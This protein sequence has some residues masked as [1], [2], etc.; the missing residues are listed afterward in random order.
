MNIKNN[1]FWFWGFI[2][3]AVLVISAVS[4]VGYKAYRF[5]NTPF[6][7]KHTERPN[8]RWGNMNFDED[9]QKFIRESRIKHRNAMFDL[10]KQQK[11]IHNKL[12][13][14]IS[15]ENPDAAIIQIYKDSTLVLS[16]SIMNETIFFY[17]T[18]KTQLSHEQMKTINNHINK[19]F[20]KSPRRR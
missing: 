9:Q 4:T 2:I 17:E 18:L 12:F 15:K 8:S 16:T 5:H 6:H 3:L 20:H 19:G 11:D 14:E 7:N 1:Q 10:K 13:L